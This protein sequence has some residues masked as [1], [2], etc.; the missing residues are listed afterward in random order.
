MRQEL[1]KL[2]RSEINQ[3]N[4]IVTTIIEDKTITIGEIMKRYGIDRNE[5]GMVSRLAKPGLAMSGMA[6]K[7]KML[8]YKYRK[9]YMDLKGGEGDPDA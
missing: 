5:Y 2:T 4:A 1:P 7:Y 9:L 6:E 8:A 3:I